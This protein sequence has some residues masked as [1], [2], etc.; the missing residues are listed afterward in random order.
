MRFVV[1]SRFRRAQKKPTWPNTLEVFSH[2]G[3]LF[4][5]P[6]AVASCS[7]SNHPTWMQFHC[8]RR[9]SRSLRLSPFQFTTGNILALLFGMA[10]ALS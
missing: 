8:E 3:L 10:M 9:V 5:E 1:V 2:V 7:L 6:L 4:N